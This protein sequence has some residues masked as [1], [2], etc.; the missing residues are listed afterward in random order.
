MRY[1][2]QPGERSDGNKQRRQECEQ[3]EQN[4]DLHR[5]R[6]SFTAGPTADAQF[7]A[8]ETFVRRRGGRRALGNY[9]DKHQHKCES[10]QPN[11]GGSAILSAR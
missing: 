5:N 9:Q 7:N 4:E 8:G 1:D 11:S 10:H 3:S 2:D 6:Q